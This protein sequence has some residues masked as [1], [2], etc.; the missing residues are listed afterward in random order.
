[1]KYEQNGEVTVLTVR[2]YNYTVKHCILLRGKL[3]QVT[4]ELSTELVKYSGEMR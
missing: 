3:L 1:M 4:L 2:R